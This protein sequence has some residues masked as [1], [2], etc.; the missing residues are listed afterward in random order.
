MTTPNGGYYVGLDTPSA[1]H[2]QTML[3]Y[4]MNGKPLTE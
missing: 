2:E 1:L 4:E 3:C